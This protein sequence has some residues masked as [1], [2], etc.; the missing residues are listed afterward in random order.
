MTEKELENKADEWVELT[1]DRCY[2]P[3]SNYSARI[4]AR[5]AFIAGLEYNNKQL[6]K[7]KEIIKDYLTIVKGSHTTECGVPE[8]NRTIYVLQLNEEA[9]QFIK[10]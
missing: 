4:D 3:D 7:A 8:E 2:Y 9:E 6:T 1:Y 10:E 5:N